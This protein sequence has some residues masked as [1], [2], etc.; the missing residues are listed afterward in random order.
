MSLGAARRKLGGLVKGSLRPIKVLERGVSPRV[1]RAQIVGSRRA[2]ERHRPAAAR[3]F[4]LFDT[5]ATF[6]VVDDAGK[7][8]KAEEDEQPAAEPLPPA[9]SGGQ[10]AAPPAPPPRPKR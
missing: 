2:H 3:R 9:E 5:W 10:P 1:V 8:K 4:G 7:T 6:T